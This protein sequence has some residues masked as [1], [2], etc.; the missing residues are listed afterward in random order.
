MPGSRVLVSFVD[1]SPGR[2]IIV[3]FE[4]AEGIGFT[5]LSITI[6]ATLIEIGEGAILGAARLTDKVVAGPFGGAIT[7]SSLQTRIA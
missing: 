1:A 7:T 4:E 2:P 6:D 3:A 5:P